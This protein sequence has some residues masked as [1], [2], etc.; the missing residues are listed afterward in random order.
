[1]RQERCLHRWQ[2]I[3]RSVQGCAGRERMAADAVGSFNRAWNGITG[4]A[5]QTTQII[6]PIKISMP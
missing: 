5:A 3:Q 4:L 6:A 2:I 1:M